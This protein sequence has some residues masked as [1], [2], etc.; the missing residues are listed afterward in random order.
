MTVFALGR[1]KTR[2]YPEMLPQFVAVIIKA[3]GRVK[4]QVVVCIDVTL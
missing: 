2:D 4:R 1:H 3:V